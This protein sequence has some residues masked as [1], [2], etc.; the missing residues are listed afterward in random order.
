MFSNM[1]KTFL[2]KIKQD[3]L[4]LRNY[5]KY[6]L[7]D[8][9]SVDYD[10]YWGSKRKNSMTILSKWQKQRADYILNM[11]EPNS[12]V[13][14]LGCGDGAVLKYLAEKAK[15][16]GIGVDISRKVLDKAEQVGIK[17]ITM[18]IT[19]FTNLKDLPE[20]D[21]ILGLEIIEHLSNPEEFISKIKD[22]AKKALIFSI[23]NSGYYSYRLKL[24]GGRFPTQWIVHPG[25]HLRFWT[26]QDIKW[27]VNALNLK[28]DQLIVYEGLPFLN[29][30]FPKVFGK[31]IIIKIIL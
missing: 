29:K 12:L 2:Y 11:I 21:Y 5:P 10:E 3:F 26:V 30:I 25:E 20:V 22:K 4:S 31:G 28:L 6:N 1:F 16:K 18:D 15:I 9:I 14:D 8:K 24:L 13:L 17:T 7:S 19:N 27:W 23:P